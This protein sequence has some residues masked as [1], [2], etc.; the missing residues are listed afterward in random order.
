[1]MFIPRVI[2]C[3]LLHQGG[4]VKTIRF[5]N[6]RYIGDPINTVRIFNEKEVD[7][8][9]I[10]DI[11]A[12]VKNKEPDYGVIENIVSEAFM[13]VCYGGGITS[14]EQIRRLFWVGV[15]KVS[16]SSAAIANPS[17]IEDAARQFGSQSIV[18]TL[19]ITKTLLKRQYQVVTHN[20]TKKTGLDPI[21]TAMLMEKSGAGELV[22]NN[23]DRDGTMAGYDL[24]YIKE[25]TDS[26][27]IPVIALGGAGSLN[28]IKDVVIKSGASAAAAGSLFIYYGRLKAVLINYPDQRQLQQLFGVGVYE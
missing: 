2:P 26:V 3:L 19:D 4:L 16:I 14:I 13:P 20:A 6:P 8:L 12:T 5:K 18:V 22:I 1:M 23:V 10:L 17:L 25:I 24:E 9:I 15:E 11:D 28:D 7:E 27:G 21:K